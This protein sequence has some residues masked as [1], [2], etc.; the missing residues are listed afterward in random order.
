MN[1]SRASEAPPASARKWPVTLTVIMGTVAVVL[2][3]TVVNV[4]IPPIMADF[5]MG[6]IAA[7]WLATGFMAA[8][9]ATM[10]ASARVMERFGQRRTFELAI[11]VFL[12]ACVLAAMSPS[13]SV[14]IAARVLQGATAGIIQPLGLVMIFQVFD[15]SERGKALGMYGMGVVLA[16]AIGPAV[17]GVLIDWFS[18]R[19]IYLPAIPFGLLALWGARRYFVDE[20]SPS[21]VAF[22]WLGLALLCASLALLLIG[23]SELSDT[24]VRGCVLIATGVL[25]ML[26]FILRALKASAPLIDLS[27]LAYPRFALASLLAM[28]YGAGLYGST[29]LLPLMAQSVQQ[30]SAGTTGLVMMPAGLA[31]TVIFPIAGRLADR[32]PA[33]RLMLVGC[34]GFAIGMVGLAFS[35]PA[36]A[37]VALAGWIAFG[38]MALGVMM[39]ALNI[40]GLRSLPAQLTHQGSGMINFT[41]QLGG[42]FGVNLFALLLQW[43]VGANMG[44]T[45]D[46]HRL[47]NQANPAPQ[48]LSALTTGFRETFMVMALLFV[49]AMVIA[50]WMG[51]LHAK[52]RKDSSRV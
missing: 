35:H 34:G 19:V 21:R 11:W 37:F 12:A 18:W 2:N 26:A 28:F 5:G 32:M 41:R 46:L 10:L 30:F 7:Q 51:V 15:D 36:T 50:A 39:P 44:D 47:F 49:V 3:A 45:I 31:L 24:P 17:G 23:L 42:A 52:F 27:V 25:A 48:S 1:G 16:P 43:R 6:Q 14:M 4:A 8:M 9:T 13:S 22:D 40:D 20:V 29:Y 38:R 33:H